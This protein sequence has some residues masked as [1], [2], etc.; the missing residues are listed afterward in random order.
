MA[1]F[2]R[3]VLSESASCI[4]LILL[5]IVLAKKLSVKLRDSNNIYDVRKL[6]TLIVF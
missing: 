1:I 3:F 6:G 4:W 5:A 2:L